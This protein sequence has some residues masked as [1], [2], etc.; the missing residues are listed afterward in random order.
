MPMLLNPWDF[1]V[2]ISSDPRV[3]QRRPDHEGRRVRG[4]KRGWK[5]F[6]A[7]QAGWGGAALAEGTPSTRPGDPSP[8]CAHQEECLQ[9]VDVDLLAGQEAGEHQLPHLQPFA[10]V[11]LAL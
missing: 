2:Y 7:A 6:C 11:S 10:S 3:V 5:H 9:L 1:P 4:R 8:S